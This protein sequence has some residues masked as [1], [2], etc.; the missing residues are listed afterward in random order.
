MSKQPD[1]ELQEA[2]AHQLNN[3]HL[4]YSI[5]ATG[6]D[7]GN[8]EHCTNKILA[9][10]TKAQLQLVDE[11][12]GQYQTYLDDDGA[13]AIPISVLQQYKANLSGKGE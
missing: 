9:L 1:K 8:L 2:I 7:T 10:F 13:T 11:L 4:P 5:H 3:H 6:S 12:M